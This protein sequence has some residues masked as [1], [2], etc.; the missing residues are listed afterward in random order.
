MTPRLIIVALAALVATTVAA[1]APKA[2]PPPPP[3][4]IAPRYPHFPTPE[5]PA[6]LKVAADISDRHAIAWRRLQAGDH[7]GA[8]RDFLEL[9]KR[10]PSFYPAE[11]GL[12]YVHLAER[13]FKSAATRFTTAT[14]ANPR[15]LPAWLGQV[16][17]Q[18]GL[19]SDPGAIAALE[20][21]VALDPKRESARTRL[22]LLRFKQLQVVLEAARRAKQANRLPE[23]QRTLEDALALAPNSNLVLRELAVVEH[24]RGAL[25]AAETHIRRAIQ[26]EPADP[27][28]YAALG[29]IL[30]AS[31]RYRD[32][33]AAYTKAASIDPRPAWV[34]TAAA[35]KEKA[36]NA[37]IPAEFR[38]LPA[39]PSVTRAQ[40]AAFIGIRLEE[41]ITAAPKRV[42]AVATDIRNHWANEWIL[43]VT[44]AGVMDIFA[45]HTFQPESLVRRSDLAQIVGQLLRLA[46]GA[47]SPELARWRAERPKFADLPTTHLSYGAAALAVAA[48][49]MSA[50]T[51]DRFAAT[52]PAT[53]RDVVTAIARIDQ[54]ATR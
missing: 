31:S 15:Y 35:L 53:G 48:N 5:I 28:S 29:A 52:R 13:Q 27:E 22:D 47:K 34:D 37:S 6:S 10:L 43:S 46:L 12:G 24:A 7:R 40:L 32:A 41:L 36:I 38:E 50:Q 42:A 51:G 33:A 17:A 21:V 49:A 9:I 3:T 39:A 4:G 18:L 23:A 26:I 19:E 8:Q 16:E 45:N 11:T 14:A 44:Q 54:L 1:C 30:E 20:R 25:D 2:P